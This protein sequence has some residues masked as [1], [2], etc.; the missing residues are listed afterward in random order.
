MK[1][2]IYL[3]DYTLYSNRWIRNSSEP[4]HFNP[5]RWAIFASKDKTSWDLI[6]KVGDVTGDSP[7]KNVVISG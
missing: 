1:E 2:F 3:R 6:H 7:F 4:Y 5:T